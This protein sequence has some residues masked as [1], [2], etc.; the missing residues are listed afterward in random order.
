MT[1]SPIFPLWHLAHASDWAA[2]QDVGRYEFSTRGRTL[3][4]E[5]FI[6]CSYP[7]QVGAVART[8]YADDPEELLVLEVDREVLALMGIE[9][10]VEPV[11]DQ[12]YPHIYGPIPVA[13]VSTIR[14]A[15]FDG[16]RGFVLGTPEPAEG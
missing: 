2:A 14:A 15:A 6:H 13:A 1:D 11:G 8:F 3:A 7:H 5:G 10:R 16:G 9:V 4:E 12:H